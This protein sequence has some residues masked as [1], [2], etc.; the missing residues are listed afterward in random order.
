MKKGNSI[1]FMA[2]RFSGQ[3]AVGGILL[4]ILI[5]LLT[6]PVETNRQT[7]SV[8]TNGQTTPQIIPI[9]SVPQQTAQPTIEFIP[10]PSDSEFVP[11]FYLHKYT[12]PQQ[13]VNSEEYWIEVVLAEQVLYVYNGNKLITGFRIS[14][15]KAGTETITGLFKIYALYE[16]YPIWWA[17]V[18]YPDTPYVMFFHGDYA[19]HGAY[20]HDDFGTPV[21]HG[22]VN[23]NVND[24]EWLYGNVGKGTYVYIHQ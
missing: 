9:V 17:G 12:I 18:S 14:S 6:S 4:L 20:W 1:L 2:R 5:L 13:L 15:G 16:S 24:A 23:M 11:N 3:F 7:T 19:I 22:C 10:T 21:S 8:K